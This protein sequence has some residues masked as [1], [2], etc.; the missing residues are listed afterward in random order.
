M[1][2]NWKMCLQCDSSQTS[3]SFIANPNKGLWQTAQGNSTNWQTFTG[4]I[5]NA[6]KGS[7]D[8]LFI[9]VVD[10]SSSPFTGT[11]MGY[12]IASMKE[13]VN[14]TEVTPFLVNGGTT[15]PKACVIAEPK[16]LASSAWT[17]GPYQLEQTGDFELTFAVLASNPPASLQ[18]ASWEEDPEFDVST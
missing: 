14:Q 3:N 9:E 4:N 5:P 13:G 16:S 12:L 2:T 17:W 15:G 6:S 10:A 7:S 8:Q 11:M 18:S 1:P